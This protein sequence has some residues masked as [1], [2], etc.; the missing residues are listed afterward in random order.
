MATFNDKFIRDL[1]VPAKGRKV[2]F[3]DHRDSPIGF[4]VR[5]SP[6]GKRVFIL[7]YTADGKDRL[8][9]IGEHPIWTLTAARKKA[10]EFKREIDGG[11]DLLQQRRIKRAELTLADVIEQYCGQYADK[12]KS[13]PA[14]RGALERHAVPV[15]GDKKITEVRRREIIDLLEP[16]SDGKQRMAGLVLGYIKRVF[17]W[18]ED[19]EIIESNPVAT[20]TA[21]K[22]GQG[23]TASA[24]T[25]VLLDREIMALWSEQPEGMSRAVWLALRFVLL[26]GQRPGEVLQARHSDVHGHTWTIPAD[27]RGKTG[28]DHDVPLTETA[29]EIIEQAGGEHYL[30]E[31]YRGQALEVNAL[32][33]AVQRCATALQADAANRWRPHDLRRTMRTGLAAS[34]V[35]ETVAELAVGHVRKGIAAVYD[36]HKYSIEKRNALEAWERRLLAIAERREPDSSNVVPMVSA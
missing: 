13:G 17:T 36:Q 31:R 6:K 10:Q 22:I 4:G 12:L 30:F 8:M 9:S 1:E 27:H 29:L 5:V 14:V 23:L 11:T 26:T 16:L 19:R 20:L 3:D 25:R 33:K 21:N 24:R 2:A 32:S 34:G 18:A 7:R 35:S 15:L 28:D